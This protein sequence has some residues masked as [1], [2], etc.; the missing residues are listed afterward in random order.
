MT[1]AV[2]TI[3]WVRRDIRLRDN[4]ALAAAQ[5]EGRT[6][7]VFPW[8]PGIDLWPNRRRSYL[9]ASLTAFDEAIGGRLCVRRGTAADVILH[10]AKDLGAR[11]VVASEEH[12]P[13]GIR[14][15]LEVGATLQ[16]EGVRL[17]FVGD[18]YAAPPGS[19][20]KADDSEYLVFSAF[21]RS[22]LSHGIASPF[23]VAD[24]SFL[25]AMSSTVDL[26]SEIR[27]GKTES[28]PPEKPPTPGE[29][30]ALLRLRAF[31]ESGL[32]TYAEDRDRPDRTGTSKLSVALAF[33]EIHP[34]TVIAATRPVSGDGARAYER[35]LSWRDFHADTLWRHPEALEKPLT[36]VFTPSIPVRQGRA[37]AL[38]DAW[39]EGRTGY[40][41]VDAGMR[42][43]AVT[44]GMGNR[45]R[46]VSASFLV[47][48]LHLPW[49]LGADHYRRTLLDY[50]PAQN[51]M[52]WQWVA[53]TGRDASPFFRVFNPLAQQRR[54][55]SDGTYVSRWVPEHGSDAYPE[56]IVDHAVERRIALLGH[57]RARR[58]A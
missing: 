58:R 17:E 48:D 22:W 45:A 57:R 41:F 11:L 13:T 23:P 15:Q 5:A 27:M 52:N 54:F 19:V 8:T 33:G 43:L 47:K 4:P 42:E 12:S 50:D 29:E 2:A 9:A 10:A 14:T 31:V 32:T 26:E 37:E 24:P 39:R 53:G 6:V 36:P 34:R 38:F 7:G 35:Q 46:M 51:Q 55:D 40:P 44:G 16:R 25:L 18:A 56:P 1:P 28:P 21:H 3:W 20:S 49:Q 30:Q